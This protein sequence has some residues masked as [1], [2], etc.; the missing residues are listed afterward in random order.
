ML[1][2]DFETIWHWMSGEV[3]DLGMRSESI[4]HWAL[5]QGKKQIFRNFL[6]KNSDNRPQK[7]QE[8][9][10]LALRNLL[11]SVDRAL[12]D[13]RISARVRRAIV[14][15]F[16]SRVIIGEDDRM[17]PFREKHG[18]D[19]PSFVTISPTKKC[20]LK[21]KGCYAESC[22]ANDETLSYS[23]VQRVIREKTE[24]WGSH[25]TVIS[26][27]EP[28]IY[29][30]EGKDLFDLLRENQ[31]NY[32]MMYTNS[33]LITPEVAGKMAAL[34]NITPAISVEGW[35]KETDER[36]GR[37][38]FRKIMQAMENLRAVGVPFGV[39]VTAT[40]EN[41]E[42]ILSDEL[43]DFYFNEQGAVYGWIFQYMPIG[44]SFTVDL[45]V[46]PE[47]RRW[48][49]EQELK[50]VY[51]NRLFLV[52]FW[53][54]GPMSVGCIAAGRPGG[55]FYIDWNGNIAPCVFFPY[56]IHNIHDIYGQNLSLT[57]VL[58]SRFFRSIRDWQDKYAYD[59]P[60]EKVDN[61]F[62]PCSIRDHYDFASQAI[63]EFDAKPM[64]D[65]AAKAIEDKGYR[66]RMLAYD[67]QICNLLD[68]IWEKEGF[69]P[70][71]GLKEPAREA[72]TLRQLN[73]KVAVPKR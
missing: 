12:S 32:F 49:L 24:A 69:T 68:P 4:R 55:Y 59:Q 42:L 13:G 22:A 27:G 70:F 62:M 19:P 58:E 31:D 46:T 15:N 34:G 43:M 25:F 47:Q 5:R 63:E 8:M 66:E 3:L 60:P 14:K 30:S 10:Y 11:Y 38:V 21:C 57:D 23:I 48:M 29:R 39:S 1:S 36:R 50:L 40:R 51:E 71:S 35:E 6:V 44:R 26:G 53:N 45:M 7:V 33:T 41:A 72:T 52:D 9:R 73:S 61:L 65:N 28:L 2:S 18:Y 54:G 64:D 67:K 17:R 37:G 20:N 56:Y 16:I